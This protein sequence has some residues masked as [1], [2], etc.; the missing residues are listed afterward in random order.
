MWGRRAGG[1][2]VVPALKSSFFGWWE[3]FL[4]YWRELVIN[5]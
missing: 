4:V 1:D 3:R 5:S 2:A